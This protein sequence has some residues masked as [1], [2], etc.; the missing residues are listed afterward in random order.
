MRLSGFYLF[1]IS[2]FLILFSF[3]ASIVILNAKTPLIF[4]LVRLLKGFNETLRFLSLL[5]FFPFILFCFVKNKFYF[6]FLSLNP[7]KKKKNLTSLF[8]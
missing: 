4:F 3:L 6:L 5:I 7:R 2:Y 8:D 1:F